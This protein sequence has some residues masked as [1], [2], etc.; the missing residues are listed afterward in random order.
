MASL[1]RHPVPFVRIAAS[2]IR[3]PMRAPTLGFQ[4]RFPGGRTLLNYSEGLHRLT[5]PAEVEAVARRLSTDVLLF[6]VEPEDVE[7]IPRWVR[8]LGSPE[9]ILY[10]A[11]RPW[12]ELFDL[13]YVDLDDVAREL[14]AR[15][16]SARVRTVTLPGQRLEV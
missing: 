10:E 2:E 5:D 16:P 11:H 12:R 1:L 15:V 13:P 8:V 7:A 6:A 3:L 4:V 9:V 14:E